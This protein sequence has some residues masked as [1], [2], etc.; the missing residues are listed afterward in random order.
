MRGEY[1]EITESPGQKAT[2]EQLERLY[3]RYHFAS[4][5][6]SGGSVLE[7]ACGSGLGLGYLALHASRVVGGDIDKKNLEAATLYYKGRENIT[8]LEF[9]AHDLPFEDKSFDTVILFEA[10]YYLERPEQFV[11]E[12]HRVLKNGGHLIISTVN[13]SWRDFHPSKYSLTYYSVPELS[14]LLEKRFAKVQI[15]G[16]FEVKDVC[17]RAKVVSVIKRTASKMNVIPG[18]LRAR[19]LLKRVFVGKLEPI[20][21][22]IS[23]G[24]TSYREPIPIDDSCSTEKYKI[25]HAMTRKGSAGP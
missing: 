16:A 9:D 24:M 20:P 25:L 4:K 13:R 5:Y 14:A 15:Y 1:S 21:A 3:Q 6:L 2:R 23:D 10:I 22:E 17:T 18:S 12:A 19:E 7:V 11:S 8:V